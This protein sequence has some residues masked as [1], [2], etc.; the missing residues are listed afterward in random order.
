MKVSIESSGEV[1]WY[2]DAENLEGMAST[3]YIKDGTQQKIIA[4]LEGALFQ[5]KGQM[6]CWDD[7][8]AVTDIS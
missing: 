3:G 8:N 7:G 4:A 2:R 5:A 1:I 6:L